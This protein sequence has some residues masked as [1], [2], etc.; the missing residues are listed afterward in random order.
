MLADLVAGLEPGHIPAGL[1]AAVHSFAAAVVLV[2]L[3]AEQ[4]HLASAAGQD[5]VLVGFAVEQIHPV[6]LVEQAAE[7]NHFEAVPSLQTV[8]VS[9]AGY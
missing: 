9:L 5:A 2:D 3:A 6:V 4:N 1:A 8:T 7:Q